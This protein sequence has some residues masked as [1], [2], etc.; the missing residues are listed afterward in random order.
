M[1]NHLFAAPWSTLLRTVSIGATL[2]LV[3]VGLTFCF[4]PPTPHA[5]VRIA[6]PVFSFLL[7]LV[8]AL[9]AV[10]GYFIQGRSLFIQ[11][12]LWNT[13]INLEGLRDATVD[14]DAMRRALR[15]CGNGGLFSFTG[16]FRNKRLGT[17]RAFVTDPRQTV[18]LSFPN[19]TIV[20]SPDRPAAFVEAISPTR[21]SQISQG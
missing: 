20:L 18:V 3:G 19:R 14:P 5:W 10:R 12:L 8:C 4:L 16:W 2:L 7:P 11:R 17:F 6:V 15:L 13:R 9:F 21:R 1:P